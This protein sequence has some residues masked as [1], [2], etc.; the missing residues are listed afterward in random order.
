MNS[1]AKKTIKLIAYGVVIMM[2]FLLALLGKHDSK[3]AKNDA[4]VNLGSLF[5]DTA[6]ADAPYAEGSYYSQGNYGDDDDGDDG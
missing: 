6:Y 3:M 2:G 5:A 4:G 1:L